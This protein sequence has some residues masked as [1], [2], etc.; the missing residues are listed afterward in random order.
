MNSRCDGIWNRA[1]W[2]YLHAPTRCPLALLAGQRTAAL[3]T[4]SSL[5][6]P[7]LALCLGRVHPVCTQDPCVT[8]LFHFVACCPSYWST[9]VVSPHSHCCNRTVYHQSMQPHGNLCFRICLMRFS[10][11]INHFADKQLYITD[12]LSRAPVATTHLAEDSH[13]ERFVADVVSLLP[14]SDCYRNTT[15]QSITTPPAQSSLSLAS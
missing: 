6:T 8:L 13:T 1:C 2:P 4:V 14:A 12:T 11:T 3:P 10:Y 7:Q 15:R 9:G 5:H